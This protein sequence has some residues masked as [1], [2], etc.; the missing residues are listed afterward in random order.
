MTESSTLS[1]TLKQKF[2]FPLPS[3]IVFFKVLLRMYD[4]LI[5]ALLLLLH[6]VQKYDL[7]ATHHSTHQPCFGF[8]SAKYPI[9][10][11]FMALV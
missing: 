8:F 1:S 9:A 6:E 11:L 7:E 2:H 10:Q 4:A 5:V 3:R